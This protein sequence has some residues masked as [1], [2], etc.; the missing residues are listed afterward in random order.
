VNGIAALVERASAQRALDCSGIGFQL[1][2]KRIDEGCNDFFVTFEKTPLADF[3]ASDQTRALQRCQVGRNSGL[4]KSGALINL[5]CANAV[6]RRV[7]LVRKTTERVFEPDEN[8]PANRVGQSFY[9]FVEVDRHVVL[10]M[11]LTLYRDGANFISVFRDIQIRFSAD[12]D[13]K[14]YIGLYRYMPDT[15]FGVG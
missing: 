4:R 2:Q 13:E 8:L 11:G 3:L 12:D 15:K 9:Y 14:R 1:K 6:F 5:A 10:N 7:C